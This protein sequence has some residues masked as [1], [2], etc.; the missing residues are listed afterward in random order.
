MSKFFI[1]LIKFY[2]FFIK[3]IF[4]SLGL[5]SQ[6]QFFPSCSEYAKI[7]FQKYNSLKAFYLTAKRIIRCH[8]WQKNH[9]DP[10]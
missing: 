10:V 8:P 6:C 5:K 7:A 3:P 4:I 2:Q 9:F 1:G